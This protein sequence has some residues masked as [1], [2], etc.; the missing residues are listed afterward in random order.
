MDLYVNGVVFAVEPRGGGVVFVPEQEGCP[1]IGEHGPFEE[2][3]SEEEAAEL[4]NQWIATE[5]AALAYPEGY[6]RHPVNTTRWGILIP[7]PLG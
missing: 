4:W 2:A 5:E 6:L 3:D 1:F 7:A